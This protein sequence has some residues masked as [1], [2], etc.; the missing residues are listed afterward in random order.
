MDALQAHFVLIPILSARN[1]RMRLILTDGSRD[2]V[3]IVIFDPPHLSVLIL[4]AY[5]HTYILES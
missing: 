3:F 2:F 1:A 4:V 5:M